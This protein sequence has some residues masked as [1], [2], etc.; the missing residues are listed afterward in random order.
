M[1][2]ATL[3]DLKKA[4]GLDN[5][6]DAIAT[7]PNL[8]GMGPEQMVYDQ[9]REAYTATQPAAPA[10]APLTELP[11]AVTTSRGNMPQ[12]QF[13]QMLQQF[14]G[15][16]NGV[17]YIDLVD[18]NHRDFVQEILD[19]GNEYT[20]PGVSSI[21]LNSVLN[22]EG[23]QQV[24]G[25][26]YSGGYTHSQ[27]SVASSIASFGIGSLNDIFGATNAVA[28]ALG[29]GAGAGGIGG[30]GVSGRGA[31]DPG[32]MGVAGGLAGRGATGASGGRGPT[33]SGDTGSRGGHGVG[34]SRGDAY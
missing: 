15:S 7:N 2:N 21:G 22:G 33:G 10:P 17:P 31:S 11:T 13:L 25:P 9:A 34:G 19:L 8:Y 28:D 12:Q 29:F 32:V 26:G 23:G 6:Q 14:S 3:Q 27:P 16:Q 20:F 24:G 18:E 30:Y 5:A 1:N 4:L